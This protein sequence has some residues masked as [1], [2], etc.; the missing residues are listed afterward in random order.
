MHSFSDLPKSLKPLKMLT[1][2]ENKELG[3]FAPSVN[4]WLRGKG[5]ARMLTHPPSCGRSLQRP[6]TH[7]CPNV[8]RTFELHAAAFSGSSPFD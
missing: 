4:P 5:L 7:G 2:L 8:H 3:A 6:W 1:F